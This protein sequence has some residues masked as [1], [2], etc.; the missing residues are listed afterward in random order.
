M[1]IFDVQGKMVHNEEIQILNGYYTRN[2][3][4]SGMS[5]GM[6]FV[7]LITQGQRLSGKIVKY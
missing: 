3:S 1:E 6:Y 4:M 7:N 2:F 5:E